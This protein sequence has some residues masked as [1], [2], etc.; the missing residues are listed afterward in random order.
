[1]PAPVAVNVY[2]LHEYNDY[3][4]LLG[5]GI[6]HSGLEVHGREYAFGGH[7]H[8]SSGIFETAPR[9][10][11]PPARFRSTEIVGYTDM[12]PAEVADVVAELDHKFHGNTYHLLERNCNVFVEAMCAE[13]TGQAPP[14]WVNRLARI[15]VMS[16]PVRAVHTAGERACGRRDAV[17]G[18]S[19][20]VRGR[21]RRRQRRRRAAPPHAAAAD[22]VQALEP[23]R[24]GVAARDPGPAATLETT[25]ET[26]AGDVT[27][28]RRHA[29][30]SKGDGCG[31]L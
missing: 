1:M 13:L 14:P 25:L 22:H 18:P 11:P 9:E 27:R 31:A 24:A 16:E 4:Y 3:A 28:C 26:D 21:Q 2:D 5:V 17:Y 6:F 23:K 8:A 20:R 30:D 10:A 7:D 15:A 19:G 29:I 12:T